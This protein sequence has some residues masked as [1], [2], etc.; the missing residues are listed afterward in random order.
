MEEV[1]RIGQK[2]ANAFAHFLTETEERPIEVTE[3]LGLGSGGDAH[4]TEPEGKGHDE[5]QS[6][7]DALSLGAIGKED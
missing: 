3:A 7:D 6:P 4:V 5:D 1:A 2:Q